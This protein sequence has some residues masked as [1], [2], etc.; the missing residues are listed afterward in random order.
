MPVAAPVFSVQE[1]SD[2][3]IGL[4]RAGKRLVFTN[5]CFDLLHAGHI[6]YLHEAKALG[7]T[8]LVGL[9]SDNS[10]RQLKGPGRPLHTAADRAAILDS[11]SA[12]D[13]VVVF[14]EL[15]AAP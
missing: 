10:V 11:V 14:D 12:V 5:G 13:G 9:N 15:S 1:A 6:R 3:R 8:L 2:L 7:D 4:E